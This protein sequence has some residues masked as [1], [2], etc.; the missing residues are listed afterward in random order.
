MSLYS[1]LYI[2]L[3]PKYFIVD[4]FIKIVQLRVK[5][6]IF[7]FQISTGFKIVSNYK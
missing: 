6:N 5:L 7:N 2:Y 1:K 4:V 3:Y